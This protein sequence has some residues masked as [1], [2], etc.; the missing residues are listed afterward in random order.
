[1]P[2]LIHPV[3]GV[4]GLGHIFYG[5]FGVSDVAFNVVAPVSAFFIP[6][7]HQFITAV[8]DASNVDCCGVPGGNAE[9]Y[10]DYAKR[11]EDVTA[12]LIE[13]IG[14]EIEPVAEELGL[15]AGAY[16]LRFLPGYLGV[17]QGAFCGTGVDCVVSARAGS[18]LVVVTLQ[19][20]GGSGTCEASRAHIDLVC[21]GE[22][23]VALT[24]D[25]VVTHKAVAC[26]YLEEGEPRVLREPGLVGED[27]SGRC[28]REETEPAV[29]GEVLRAVE[30]EI[31]LQ[32]IAGVVVVGNT[33]RCSDKAA[34]G[35]ETVGGHG[36][37]GGTAKEEAAHVMFP[38]VA[39]IVEDYIGIE[40]THAAPGAGGIAVCAN[41]APEEL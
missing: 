22:I 20:A 34:G 19:G 24:T 16:L 33:G 9:G 27:V 31:Q 41:R 29:C 30:R 11:C 28:R 35:I 8:G 17:T 4:G 39:L 1:M 15:K 21:A 10:G 14:I 6:A 3:V 5:V 26:P 36:V 7:K 37:L 25:L 12:V 18:K 40:V 23:E 32:Q 2:C 13:E 38:K